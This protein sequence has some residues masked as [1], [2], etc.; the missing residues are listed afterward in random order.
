MFE[1]NKQKRMDLNMFLNNSIITKINN[2]ENKHKKFKHYY[3]KSVPNTENDWNN[4]IKQVYYDF[5]L[6]NTPRKNI[7][8]MP[9]LNNNTPVKQPDIVTYSEMKNKNITYHLCHHYPLHKYLN[10][11][12]N[13]YLK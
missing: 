9:K 6:P 12:I 2:I 3:F 10:P 11:I 13:I 5:Q 4:V 1:K 7:D 8:S